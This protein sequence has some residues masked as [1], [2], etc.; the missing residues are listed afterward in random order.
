MTTPSKLSNKLSNPLFLLLFAVLLAGAV[1]WLAF[2]YLEKREASIKS[3]L[4]AQNKKRE[5]I[6]VAVVVPRVDAAIN[7]V[8]NGQV[9]VS[10]PIEED[11]VY[12]DTILA[13]DFE[14]M[15]GQKLARPVLRGRPVRLAD[16]Q[17][18]EVNDVASVVPV[19]SRAMTIDIDNLNS[20]AQTLRPNHRVDIFLMSKAPRLDRSAADIDEKTLEQATLF[21]Q[22]MV[23]LATGQQ[24]MDVSTSPDRT[25]QMTRPGAVVGADAKEK[26]FDSITL[27]VSPKEAAR[28]L[29]GQKMGTYRV[30]LRGT[31]DSEALKLAPLRSGDL[32]PNLARKRD[33]PSIEFIAG[34]RGDNLVSRLPSSTYIP[35]IDGTRRPAIADL[36]PADIAA[37]LKGA[38]AGAAPSSPANQPVPA[39]RNSR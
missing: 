21:M 8:F 2:V 26:N 25:A 37:A 15:E 18:P 4:I 22:N 32:M 34:G 7:T 1:A 5:T 24:F 27:L 11:L 14:A 36:I 33:A 12:P 28:L 20:I 38:A 13:K 39:L 30:V 10:R 35:Q 3:D 6:M 23:I 16:L 31:K 17:V 29:V 19:G 9:F